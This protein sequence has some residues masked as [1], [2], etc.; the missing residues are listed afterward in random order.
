MT[1]QQINEQKNLRKSVAYHF[2]LAFSILPIL[3]LVAVGVICSINFFSIIGVE[4][5]HYDYSKDGT[6]PVLGLG[7]FIFG[8]IHFVILMMIFYKWKRNPLEAVYATYRNFW[9]ST[10]FAFCITLYYIITS[11][12]SD[13]KDYLITRVLSDFSAFSLVFS[14]LGLF[15][16]LFAQFA[17]KELRVCPSKTIY[18]IFIFLVGVFLCG[19]YPSYAQTSLEGLRLEPNIV[20]WAILLFTVKR[21]E[22]LAVPNTR[23]YKRALGFDGKGRGR[24]SKHSIGIAIFLAIIIAIG[25]IFSVV[26]SEFYYQDTLYGYMVCKIISLLIAIAILIVTAVL[27][28]FLSRRERAEEKREREEK[29]ANALNKSNSNVLDIDVSAMNGAKN[30]GENVIG[31]KDPSVFAREVSIDDA[32]QN[33]CEFAKSKGIELFPIDCV[34]LIGAMASAKVVIIKCRNESHSTLLANILGEYFNGQSYVTQENPEW[35]EVH[36][37]ASNGGA[38]SCMV[39]ATNKPASV[40]AFCLTGSKAIVSNGYFSKV[41]QVMK[42]TDGFKLL[43][44]GFGAGATGANY[45]N[46][47]LLIPDNLWAIVFTSGEENVYSKDIAELCVF[48]QLE[49]QKCTP[50]G[51]VEIKKISSSKLEEF[52]ANARDEYVLP[53]QAWRKIDAIEE[54]AKNTLGYSFSN[55]LLHVVEKYSAICGNSKI[56]D[57]YILDSVIAN[58]ILPTLS[59]VANQEFSDKEKGV[60]AEIERVFGMDNLPQTKEAIRV[61]GLMK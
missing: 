20:V 40:N 30:D 36:E 35:K 2:V 54:F 27:N 17:K 26:Y 34:K 46:G 4:T 23:T 59:S 10:I 21:F 57:S 11:T 6:L 41:V 50:S 52:T 53:E 43:S 58:V 3:A 28:I 18:N 51:E 1:T 60:Y 37:F 8:A 9:R 25:V 16:C 19:L 47:N 13:G 56:A 33:L 32:T 29:G 45:Y 39:N 44:V 61:L 42:K 48:I 38:L 24:Y 49:E 12:L 15:V 14:V 31:I 5:Y 7:S 22:V 55:E